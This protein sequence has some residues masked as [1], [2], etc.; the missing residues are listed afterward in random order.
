MLLF[1]WANITSWLEGHLLGCPFK[2]L[3]GLDCPGC[4]LQRSVIALL[5]G[6]IPG[7]LR[8]YPPGIFI[9]TVLLVLLLHLK[10]QFRHGAQ[11]IKFLF[12]ITAIIICCNYFYKIF[13]QQLA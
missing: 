11:L 1:H 6:D 9:V 10:W 4:G 7:S 13:T 5:K 2:R 3:T 8:I 12:I